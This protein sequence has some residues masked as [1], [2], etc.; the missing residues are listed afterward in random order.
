MK[1]DAIKK[2][3]CFCAA[4]V[5][6]KKKISQT[7]TESD[8]SLFWLV[9][10]LLAPLLFRTDTDIHSPAMQNHILC[11]PAS[12]VSVHHSLSA[13]GLEAYKCRVMAQVRV[14]SPSLWDL[15]L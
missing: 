4:T 6:R 11:V 12:T 8:E 2:L 3:R 1:K 14:S 15:R 10:S 7:T 9:E 13:L 5:V